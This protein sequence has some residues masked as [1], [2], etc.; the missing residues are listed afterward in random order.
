M[1]ERLVVKKE[2]QEENLCTERSFHAQN[3]LAAGRRQNP[4]LTVD[5]ILLYINS[6]LGYINQAM[7]NRILQ[8]DPSVVNI[9]MPTFK[10]VCDNNI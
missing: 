9:Y 2:A 3:R 10:D 1:N 4:R 5:E 8:G 7:T 6:K